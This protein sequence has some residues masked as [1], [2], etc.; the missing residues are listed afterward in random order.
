[1]PTG[2]TAVVMNEIYAKNKTQIPKRMWPPYKTEQLATVLYHHHA[3]P[4]VINPPTSMI[5]HGICRVA[6]LAGSSITNL[7]QGTFEKLYQLVCASKSVRYFSK[8]MGS[9]KK[10]EKTPLTDWKTHLV[11]RY[12]SMCSAELPRYSKPQT[13]VNSPE[14]EIPDF[15]DYLLGLV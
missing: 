2:R 8:V 12:Q 13:I 15:Q 14:G 4:G 10:A 1:M 9:Q 3:N 6:I 5:K 11:Q 7:N